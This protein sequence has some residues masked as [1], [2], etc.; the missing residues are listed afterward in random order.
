M[1]LIPTIYIYPLNDQNQEEL[2]GVV[3][4]PSIPEISP[5]GG[6]MLAMDPDQAQGEE[7]KEPRRLDGQ[8]MPGAAHLNPNPA[9]IGLGSCW[10]F[11]I[12]RE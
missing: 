6:S 1:L 10:I 3:T 9:C 5:V 12:I 7:S 2:L 11:Y 8:F 4:A